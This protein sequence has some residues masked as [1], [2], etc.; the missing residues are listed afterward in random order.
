MTRFTGE[1]LCKLDAKGRLVLP[2]KLKAAIPEINGSELMMI[3]GFEPCLVLYTLLEYNKTYSKVA[4]LD[5]LKKEDRNIQRNFFRRNIDVELDN[6][7]RFII[8]KNMMQ[9]VKIDKEVKVVGVGNRMELWNP[10]VLEEYILDSEE[11]SDQVQ[12]AVTKP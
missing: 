8:P 11:L 6:T 12:M 7:G 5:E 2:A 1:Y 9:A 10:E 3:Q 4:G